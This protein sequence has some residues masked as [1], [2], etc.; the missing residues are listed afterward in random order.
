M[1]KRPEIKA[2]IFDCDGTLVDS[3][4]AHFDAWK[5]VAQKY[6]QEL[7]EEENISFAGKPDDSI[8]KY[9]AT[10]FQFEN[11]QLLWDQKNGYFHESLIQGMP[12]LE[13]TVDFLRRL[14]NERSRFKLAVASAAPKNEI[15]INLKN[16]GLDDTFDLV[17]SGQDDLG[18]YRDPEGVN[19]PK[20]YIYLKAAKLLGVSP[21]ECIAIEDSYSGVTAASRAGCFTVA[22]P[23]ATSRGQDLSKASCILDSLANLS[24][25]DFLSRILTPKST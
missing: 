18:D 6:G 11:Y 22:I 4:G 12:A 14:L 9:L 5:R 7:T 8:A 23:T 1:S 13:E 20:P 24:I 2:F 17:I 3:E 10:R 16:L 21:T 15:L 19:K 25:S